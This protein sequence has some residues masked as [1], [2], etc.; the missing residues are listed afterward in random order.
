MGVL[1]ASLSNAWSAEVIHEG[2]MAP[3][4]ITLAVLG[5]GVL[6]HYLR[7]YID[8]AMRRILVTVPLKAIVC[9]AIIVLGLLSSIISAIIAALLLVEL[10]SILP[11]HRRAEINLTIIACF[12]IGLGAALTPLGEPLSTI[13][14]SKLSGAPYHATFYYLFGLLAASVIPA[15]VVLGI[16]GTF[17]VVEEPEDTG[18]SLAAEKNEEKLSEVFIRAA[19]VYI[20]VM[21]LIFLGAGFKPLIDSYLLKLPSQILFWVNMVSAILDNATLAAAEIGPSLSTA[22]IKSALLGLL[23]SGGMLIPGNIPNIIAAH[24]LRIKSTEW[25]KLGVPLGVVIMI[26]AAALLWLGIL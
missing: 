12:A 25:A 22:Q 11:L 26:G 10:I 8:H 15:V 18:D 6:F 19:K 5:A 14:V 23:I 17:L 21:A 20:F 13:V 1:S 16:A 2:F 9:A 7:K 24:A 4:N 3:I